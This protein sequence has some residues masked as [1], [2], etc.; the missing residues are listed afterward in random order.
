MRLL[1]YLAARL[2]WVVVV[3]LGV[4]TL[5]FAVTNLVPAD[6][7]RLAAGLEA[8]REE[9]ETMRHVMGLDQPVP[10]QYLAYV[11]RLLHGDLGLDARSQRPVVTQLAQYF[12]ATLELVITTMIIYVFVGV[13]GGVAAAVKSGS[14]IDKGVQF[15]SLAGLAMPVFWLAIVLQVVFFAGL[16]W[17]P[18][19]GRLSTGLGPP[20]HV[21]GLYLVDSA[22][23][24]EWGTWRDA[25]AH[26]VLPSCALVLG[27]VANVL[28]ITRRA[29]IRIFSEPFIATARAKGLT[30]RAVIWRHALANTT[31][32]IVTW[33]GLETGYLFSGAI[34]VEAVF[35]WP[36]LGKYAVDSISDLDFPPIMGVTLIVATAFVFVNLAVDL[37]Y[38]LFDPRITY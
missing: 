13:T 19:A 3:L 12:P 32:P 17:F 9:V 10:L 15:F 31:I 21:T 26:L 25:A 27:T 8:P 28:R 16:H 20:P 24:G 22:L 38:P 36:G 29:M 23:A 5:T 30:E 1:S 33:L 7:A 37:L 6:P 11:R 4:I 2:I 14:W 34:V 35:S 18:A